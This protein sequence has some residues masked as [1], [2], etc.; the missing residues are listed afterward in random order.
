VGTVPPDQLGAV[1]VTD[2]ARADVASIGHV[3]AFITAHHDAPGFVVDLRRA[4]GGDEALAR[5]VARCFCARDTVY[6][7]SKFRDG[8]APD[9]FGPTHDRILGA[10]SHPFTRPVVC[11]LGPGCVSSGEGFAKML[12]A[13]PHVTTVGAPTRGSSGNPSPFTLPGFDISVWY[14]R[15]VDM[16]PDGTPVEGRGVVPDVRVDAPTEAY[17]D[18]DPTWE[19]AV[20]VLRAKIASRTR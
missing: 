5:Q 8:P 11:L 12:K 9:D 17:V 6:A 10:S 18:G 2:Q 7:L 19:K 16:L 20:E 14:S 15:W 1:V 13:L 3:V 4:G